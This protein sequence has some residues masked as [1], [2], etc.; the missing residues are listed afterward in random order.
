MAKFCPNC[1]SEMIDE[2]AMCVKCGTMVGENNT[3]KN[4]EEKFY[5]FVFVSHIY[6]RRTVFLQGV[7]E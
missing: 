4:N 7:G 1:G 6:K 5:F 3:N 2:A